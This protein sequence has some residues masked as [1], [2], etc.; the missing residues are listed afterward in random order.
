MRDQPV[1]STT[2]W[3]LER[4]QSAVDSL[5]AGYLREAHEMWLAMTRDPSVG[6]ALNTRKMTLAAYRTRIRWAPSVPAGARAAL[7]ERLPDAI[8][9]ADLAS[10]SAD[11]VGLGVVPCNNV[12]SFEPDDDGLFWWQFRLD[13]LETGHLSYRH[14]QRRYYFSGLGG[15]EEIV[16]DGNAWVLFKS[17]GNRRPHLDCAARALAA[18]WFVLQEAIRYHRAYNAEYG[19]PI[20]ALRV[21][22]EHRLNEDVAL[23]V[24]QAADLNGGSVIVLPQFGSSQP[25]ASYDLELIEQKSRGF[26]TFKVVADDMRDIILRYILGVS[27]TTSGSSAS[28]A[29]AQTQLRVSDRYASG[30]ARS[31]EAAVN[32][33]LRRW[34]EFNGFEGSTVYEVMTDPVEDEASVAQMQ[35]SASSAMKTAAEALAAAVG[36]GV[37]LTADQAAAAL[38]RGGWP[39]QDVTWLPQPAAPSQVAFGEAVSRA[40]ADVASRRATRD[41]GVERL[42]LELALGREQ[43]DRLLGD[44]GRTFFAEAAVAPE[45]EVRT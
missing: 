26:D 31:R 7:L 42:M 4:I 14:D 2:G 23:L 32:L 10:T 5:E 9:A 37:R 1:A 43:A 38:R 33:V 12:W 16:D 18:A 29:K 11:V 44:A 28:D 40:I 27:E 6:H 45:D 30:D 41:D 3:T 15:L 17:L 35:A 39:V 24:Q 8:T 13:V 20:K 34:M 36:A 25:I 21:P 22:D 19:R